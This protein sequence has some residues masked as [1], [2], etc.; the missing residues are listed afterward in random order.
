M[1][2]GHHRK[3]EKVF[4]FFCN[5]LE[6]RFRRVDPSLLDTFHYVFTHAGILTGEAHKP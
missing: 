3:N 5:S 1:T 6:Q 2:E 4:F